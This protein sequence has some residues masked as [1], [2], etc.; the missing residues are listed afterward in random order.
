[1][2]SGYSLSKVVTKIVA[3]RMCLLDLPGGLVASPTKGFN[4][5]YLS[6]QRDSCTDKD[7]VECYYGGARLQFQRGL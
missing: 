3:G 4:A 6:N 7:Q 5:V 2:E 1:M